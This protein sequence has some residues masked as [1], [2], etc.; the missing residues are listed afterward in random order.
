MSGPAGTLRRALSR[1]LRPLVPFGRLLEDAGRGWLAH[2]VSRMASSIAYFGIFS[3]APVL[4]IMISVASVVFGE[5]ASEGLIVDQLTETL[6]KTT[7]DL[8]QSMLAGT[9]QSRGLTLATV[10]AVL[11]LLWAA[12]RIIGAVRGALNDIW[13]V[14]GHG[15]NGF[16]G[17]VVGKF[18]D[19]AM[20]VGVG[21]MFLASMLAN[22]AVS[23]LTGYFSDLL[24]V[25][26]WSL[27]VIGIAFSLVVATA[28]L[29]IIFRVL[30]NIKICF[31][32]ILG[33]AAVTAVLF[34]VGNW[35]IGRYLGRAGPGSAFGAAG[36]LAVLMIWMY[37]SAHIVLFGAEV[38]RAYTQRGEQRRVAETA[39]TADTEVASPTVIGGS[40]AT[41]EQDVS[42]KQ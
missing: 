27:Q 41:Q 38:T 21:V 40:A 29:T 39:A 36:S 16:L 34:T 10:L 11:V 26:A 1:L 22:A 25:P 13:G 42:S 28:F 23:A 37:Y 33:G 30:P 24:P 4:V 15:G 6:G 8:I 20:V 17:Y 12:T 3:L 5:R 35:V 7:A 14:T 9:Y 31:R 18:I 19:L 32:Y 2:N